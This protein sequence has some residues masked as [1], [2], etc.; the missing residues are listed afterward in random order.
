MLFS[1]ASSFFMSIIVVINSRTS[2][3]FLWFIIYASI[4]ILFDETWFSDFKILETV[5]QLFEHLE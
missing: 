4:D 3:W 5:F 2:T 1:P